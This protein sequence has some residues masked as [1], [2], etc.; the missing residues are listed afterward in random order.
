MIESKYAAPQQ[1]SVAVQSYKKKY[2]YKKYFTQV[3]NG[4]NVIRNINTVFTPGQI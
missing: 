1:A 4:R 3:H 2:T